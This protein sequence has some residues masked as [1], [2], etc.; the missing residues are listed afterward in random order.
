M[1]TVLQPLGLQHSTYE[2][3]LPADRAARAASGTYADGKRV[4]GRWHIYP[5]MAAA[6][7]WTTASD[8]ARI[9]I[10]VSK[11]HAGRSARVLSQAMTKQM[12][13]EQKPGTGL[14]YGL[15]PGKNQ[16]RH[17]G[18]DEGFQAYLTAFAD[19][20]SGVVIMA[21][22]DN[23]FMIFDRIASS[24]AKEYRWTSFA[25]RESPFAIVSLLVNTRG[26]ERAVAWYTTARAAGPSAAF[27]PFV[28]NGAGYSLLRA[29]KT[30]DAVKLFEANVALYPDDANAYDSLGEGQM[31]A[32][33]EE[34]AI[35]NYKKSLQMNPTNAA[36]IKMLEKL[37]V[38]WTPEPKR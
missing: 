17:N 34:A 35:A 18:A 16:Y 1:E 25:T 31:A 4:E 5:E 30:A 13:T 11:A 10:E 12:L 29:G 14:G 2:Q 6:G 26:A 28:L 21:N 20:G 23:G 15:G 24:V 8:L 27:G 38:R 3:P 7:L 22:S 9:A 37:G 33:L 36:A 19:T 32:G